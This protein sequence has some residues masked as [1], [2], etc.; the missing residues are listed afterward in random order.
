VPRIGIDEINGAAEVRR[1]SRR[2]EAHAA[3][4]L[5]EESLR[6]LKRRLAD[7]RLAPVVA[8]INRRFRETALEGIERLL[9]RQG[10]VLEGADREALERWAETLARRFAHLPTLGLRGLA[11]EHGVE[12]VRSFLAACDAEALAELGDDDGAAVRRLARELEEEL[13][14]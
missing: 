9:A 5:I 2:A 12:A 8:R 1:E 7:R 14:G 6:G 3:S 10:R 4:R 11:A 13:R